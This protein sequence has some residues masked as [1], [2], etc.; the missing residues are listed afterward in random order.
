MFYLFLLHCSTSGCHSGSNPGGNLN[1]DD[2]QAFAQLS[3]PGKGY[4]NLTKPE[5][6]I[7]YTQMN[8]VSQPMPPT[9]NWK[10]VKSN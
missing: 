6:S 7:L 2:A 3:Q 4:I 10:N 5:F 8:S 1:L 9:G